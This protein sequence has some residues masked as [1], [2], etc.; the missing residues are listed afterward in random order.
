MSKSSS[1]DN[2]LSKNIAQK[3]PELKNKLPNLEND[4][5]DL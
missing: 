5:L 1:Q 3:N 4:L 2:V